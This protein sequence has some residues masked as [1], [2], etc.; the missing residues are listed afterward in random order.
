MWVQR[1]LD[2]MHLEGLFV[3]KKIVAADHFE[4]LSRDMDYYMVSFHISVFEIKMN[5]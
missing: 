1:K 4:Y 2:A 5:L 3:K